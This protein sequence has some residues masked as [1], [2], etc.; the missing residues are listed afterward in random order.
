MKKFLL[1][2]AVAA[3]TMSANADFARSF[4]KASFGTKLQSEALVQAPAPNQLASAQQKAPQRVAA[5]DPQGTVQYLNVSAYLATI[6]GMYAYDGL[7]GKLCTT[8]DTHISIWGLFPSAGVDGWANCTVEGDKVIVGSD[9]IGVYDYNGIPLDLVP[10]EFILDEEGYVQGVKTLELKKDGDRIYIDDDK[11]NPTRYMCLAAYNE[12]EYYGYLSYEM[13]YDASVMEGEFVEPEVPET[14]T[15][16]QYT[17][18]A[19]DYYG[20]LTANF[21]NLYFDGD[22]VYADQ[23]I[24]GYIVKG[25]KEGNK[26]SFAPQYIGMGTYYMFFAPFAATGEYDEE[27]YAVTAPIDAYVLTLDPETGVYSNS[28]PDEYAASATGSVDGSLY[29]YY[30]N[31]S[32]KPYLGDHAMTP[33][34]PTGVA[35]YD[36]Y[37]YYGQY[38][39]AYNLATVS[40]EGDYLNPDNLYYYLYI[41]EEQYTVT[42]DVFPYV[43]EEMDLIPSQYAD[44]AGGYDLGPGYA[45]IA[46]DMFTTMG[47]QAVYDFEGDVRYSNVVSADLEGNVYVIPA[48]QVV[49]GISTTTAKQTSRIEFYDAEGRSLRAAQRGINVMKLTATDGSVK[50]VKVMVK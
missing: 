34:D 43:A 27:G 31:V 14:A 30:N 17:Y 39:L 3:S 42:P 19:Y 47:V 21:G 33:A 23:L 2:A 8:D 15:A 45:F 9:P 41:D 28:N 25:T 24:P 6:F 5:E 26:L 48:P 32:L 22:D 4:H 1:L 10:G 49:D 35:L 7:A 11:D 50:T 12:G 37:D 18:T 38:Y 46:E 36:Y 40:T 44:E 29:D 20:D 13:C 16:A